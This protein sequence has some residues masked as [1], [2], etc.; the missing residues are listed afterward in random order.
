MYLEKEATFAINRNKLT[1][2]RTDWTLLIFWLSTTCLSA[3]LR[4][5]NDQLR[6][7]L[8]ALPEDSSNLH[9]ISPP[10]NLPIDSFLS[11]LPQDSMFIIPLTEEHERELLKQ[12]AKLL[13]ADSSNYPDYTQMAPQAYLRAVMKLFDETPYEFYG[14]PNKRG[15]F[16]SGATFYFD[17]NHL[18]SMAFSPLYRFRYKNRK[19][20]SIWKYG[21][22]A[23]LLY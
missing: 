5:N 15:K 1:M 7:K 2:K 8:P 19:K 9:L 6:I 21:E 16:S 11:T 20:A 23:Y 18:L 10:D 14:I 12:A 17:A 4:I 13:Q 22:R 3:Q